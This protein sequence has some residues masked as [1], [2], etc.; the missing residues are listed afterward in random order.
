M[1]YRIT[2]KQATNEHLDFLLKLRKLSMTEHLI[3]AGINLDD[4]QHLER[5]KD[6]YHDSKLILLDDEAIGILK[7]GN[8]ENR[9]H[10]RQFQLLPKVQNK[11]IGGKV[12]DALIERA[13]QKGLDISLYVLK[14]N[15]AKSLY[16]RKGFNI[17]EQDRLQYFMRLCK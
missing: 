15:P 2:F 13:K 12:L 9:L 4:S 8:I 6:H 16:L 3:G 11:G 7:L 5:V 14:N 1:S 17:V 10:I